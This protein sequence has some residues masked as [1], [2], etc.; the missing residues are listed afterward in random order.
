WRERG[1]RRGVYQL[2][3]T[4][5]LPHRIHAVVDY[6]YRHPLVD[7]GAYHQ[8]E[9][10][11]GGVVEYGTHQKTAHEAAHLARVRAEEDASHRRIHRGESTVGGLSAGQRVTLDGHP[12]HEDEELLVVAVEHDLQ[13]AMG[14]ESGLETCT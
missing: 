2:S 11:L 14:Q 6:N 9:E 4:V 13:T 1:E 3:T 7:L 10:G 12:R 5:A 8:L